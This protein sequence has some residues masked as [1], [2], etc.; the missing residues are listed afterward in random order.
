MKCLICFLE[1]YI[2]IQGLSNFNKIMNKNTTNNEYFFYREWC[3]IILQH[4][5][6]HSNEAMVKPYFQIIQR[7]DNVKNRS[8]QIS[9]IKRIFSDFNEWANGLDKSIILEIN[10]DLFIKFGKNLIDH[11]NDINEMVSKILYRGKIKNEIEY[12]L[13]LFLLNS[14]IPKENYDKFN[15]LIDEFEH[16]IN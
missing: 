4:I 9:Q 11:K 12:R 10:K 14:E 2:D 1:K 6:N 15:R 3:L 16:R 13:V 7:I 8:T 5:K